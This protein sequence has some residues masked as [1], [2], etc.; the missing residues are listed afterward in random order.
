MKADH[1]RRRRSGILAALAVTGTLTALVSP[2]ADADSPPASV[3]PAANATIEGNANNGLPF[4]CGS[5]EITSQRYQQVYAGASVGSGPISAIAFRPD[6]DFGAP[7]GPATIPDVTV[8]LS[9]TPAPVDELSFTFADNVGADVQTV[10][11]GDLTLS[12][13]ASGGSPRDFDI[14]ISL[15]EPFTFDAAAGNLLLDVTVP[16]CGTTTQFDTEI[17]SA[18]TSRAYTY[19]GGSTS[20][21]AEDAGAWGLVTRFSFDPVTGP[22]VCGDGWVNPGGTSRTDFGLSLVPQAGGQ[23]TGRFELRSANGKNMFQGVTAGSVVADGTGPVSWTG[24]GRWHGEAGYTF[25]AGVVDNGPSG[26]RGRDTIAI[27]VYRTSDPTD[28][29]YTTGGPQPLRGGDLTVR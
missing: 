24:T 14:V 11:R 29:V 28:V 27:A 8:T 2:G 15:S 10:H 5:H 19:F 25:E 16:T 22:E 3:V 1:R 4:N 26:A 13:A 20:P 7:F 12:S 17:Y 6:Q 21:V 18:D 23:V 9:T